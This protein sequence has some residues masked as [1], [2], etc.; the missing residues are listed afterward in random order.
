MRKLLAVVIMIFVSAMLMASSVRWAPSV[1]AYA[2][3]KADG[4]QDYMSSSATVGIELDLAA[5]SIDDHTISLPF[6]IG[7]STIGNEHDYVRK[8]DEML[9]AVEARYFHRLTNLLSLGV[10]A[11]VRGQWHLGTEYLSVSAG[12]S[13]IPSFR[14]LDP[15]SL[16][17]PVSFYASSNDCSL[18]IGIGFSFHIMEGI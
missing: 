11:G 18:M 7:Y 14:I 10:G 3:Y 17:I 12:G 15:L 9:I 16:A 13:I 2:G 1:G 6:S 8:Q 5:I 4:L